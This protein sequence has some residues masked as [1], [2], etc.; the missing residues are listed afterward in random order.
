MELLCNNCGIEQASTNW[1]AIISSFGA[2]AIGIIALFVS[3][4]QSNK[5]LTAKKEEEERSEIHKKLNEFYGPLLQLRMKSNLIYQ[6]FRERFVK[7]DSKFT[8]LTYLLDGKIIDGNE[9]IL[10]K[11]IILPPTFISQTLYHGRLI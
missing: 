8:T 1:P 7:E 11:E 9:S 2:I 3:G 5:N 4:Y 10:L 6:K